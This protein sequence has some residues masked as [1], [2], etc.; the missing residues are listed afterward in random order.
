M[1]TFLP[2]G[3]Q[4]ISKAMRFSLSSPFTYNG[5]KTDDE[6][7]KIYLE[8]N[9]FA[10]NMITSGYTKNDNK[11]ARNNFK[12]ILIEAVGTDD[13][14]DKLI[15]LDYLLIDYVYHQYAMDSS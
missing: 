7:A 6:I 1:E 14:Q 15:V 5:G 9:D 12:S 10:L 2:E 8:A 11:E 13:E 3:E 4:Y